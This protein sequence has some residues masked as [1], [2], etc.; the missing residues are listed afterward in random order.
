MHDLLAALLFGFAL[1][2]VLQGHEEEPVV[3][4]AHEAEQAEPFHGGGVLDA[5]HRSENLFDLPA[6]LVGALERRRVGKLQMQEH[7]AL[8]FVGQEAGGQPA[9]E[10]PSSRGKDGQHHERHGALANE[11]SRP[12]DITIGGAPEHAVEPAEELLQRAGRG[13]AIP[14]L[15]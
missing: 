14:R 7:V 15:Q 1:V 8:V 6:S 11:R 5:G 2:P 10:K 3:A 13:L 4:G 12:A 9:A